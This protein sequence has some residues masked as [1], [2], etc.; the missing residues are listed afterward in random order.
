M[1]CRS[2]EHC[3][4][5]GFS[6]QRSAPHTYCVCWF[7]AHGATLIAGPPALGCSSLE[8]AVVAW[9]CAAAAFSG[10][11]LAFTTPG[12]RHALCD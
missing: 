7:G 8:L 11:L 10:K 9:W 12:P 3:H 1:D 2:R 5:V 6:S 4:R